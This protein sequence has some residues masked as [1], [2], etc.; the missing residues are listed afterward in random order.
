[1]TAPQDHP[2]RRWQAP[3]DSED[4]K[5]PVKLKLDYGPTLKLNLKHNGNF[6]RPLAT[7]A[8]SL[9]FKPGRVI[10]AQ[11]SSRPSWR[12]SVPSGWCSRHLKVPCGPE[13]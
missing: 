13:L 1:M 7:Q 3:A 4:V 2:P 8:A 6:D 5:L 9:G 11:L 10:G 12:V